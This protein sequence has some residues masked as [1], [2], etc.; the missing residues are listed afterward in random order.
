MQIET[1]LPACLNVKQCFSL[2]KNHTMR[3]TVHNTCMYTRRSDHVDSTMI[4]FACA[5]IQII[6]I[7]WIA[8]IE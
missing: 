2:Q 5:I 6:F 3:Q 1:H 4:N 7:V 8:L